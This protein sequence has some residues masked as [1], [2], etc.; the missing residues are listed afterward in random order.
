[1][2]F[3]SS[4][5]LLFIIAIQ[6]ID[7]NSKPLPKILIVSSNGFHYEI[8]MFFACTFHSRGYNVTSWLH[9]PTNLKINSILD[10][11]T[12]QTF[13][14]AKNSS[15]FDDYYNLSVIITSNM[16]DI[17]NLE[18]NKLYWPLFD[19]S[20]H[21]LMVNHHAMNAHTIIKRCHV[22][23]CTMIHLAEHT[24]NSAVRVLSRQNMSSANLVYLYPVYNLTKDP[25]AHYLGKNQVVITLQG[26]VDSNR[27]N[28]TQFFNC[29]ESLEHIL[30]HSKEYSINIIGLHAKKLVHPNMTSFHVRKIETDDFQDY[31]R[32]IAASNVLNLGIADEHTY[33]HNKATSS[34]PSAILVEVPIIFTSSFITLYP[35]FRESK[36]HVKV[37]GATM[38]QSL[39]NF[40]ELKEDERFLMKQEVIECKRIYMDDSSKKI[41]WIEERERVSYYGKDK[42]NV[43][44]N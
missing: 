11:C 43:T 15:V 25:N 19:H 40:F 17:D 41:A 39:K 42:N 37:A 21:L 6:F 35:C 13:P 32:V 22:S 28:Y 1:M 4:F 18:K 36:I 34:V 7:G 8:V 5:A 16:G 20:A 31:Y 44:L 38:C 33:K 3:L 14:F 30:D 2:M 29:L 10:P 24:H 27:R 9:E 23:N 26:N 12:H